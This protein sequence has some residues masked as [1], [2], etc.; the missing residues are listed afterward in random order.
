MESGLQ[1]R[2]SIVVPVYNEAAHIRTSMAYVGKICEEASIPY[3]LV[4]IDDGS[5]DESWNEICSMAKEDERITAVRL[6]RNFGKEPALCAGLDIASGDA[7][8]VMDADLQHP[9]EKIPEMVRLW[10]EGAEVVEGVKS[11]RGKEKRSYRFCA[12]LFYGMI[13]KATGIEFD[14]ASDFKL[15]DR[16]VVDAMKQMPERMTFF[17][18]MSAWV[19][20]DR[21]T[22]E[23]EVSERVDGTSKWSL[24]RLISLAVTAVT[25]YTS[26]PL[27]CIT[28]LGIIMFLGA[29]VLGIQTVYMKL[30]GY[31]QDGFTTVILLLLLI[32]SMIMIS[33]GIIGLYL[34]K[35]YH[36]IKGRPRYLASRVIRNKE[37]EK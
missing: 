6:S 23:F 29:I 14:N 7:V 24:K 30:A 2:I 20:F 31:A 21:T 27:H 15:L 26:A 37:E 16:K 32:G 28:I 33:L 13:N 5:K 17:R 36:E 25:S 11:S 8:L 3:E 35:M 9:P 18:G 19:G 1:K 34:M 10:Q 22:F 12:K 4:L